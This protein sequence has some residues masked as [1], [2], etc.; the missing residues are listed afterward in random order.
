MMFKLGTVCYA[1]MYVNHFMSQDTLR[2]VYFSRFHFI[3]LYGIIFWGN[4]AYSCT[5]FK[6]QKRIIR[7]I[8]NVRN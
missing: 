3:L 8:M 1:I 6:I 5:I 4:S 2:T 7:A